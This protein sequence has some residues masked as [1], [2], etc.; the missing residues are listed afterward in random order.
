MFWVLHFVQFIQGFGQFHD[1]EAAEVSGDVGAVRAGSFFIECAALLDE[2]LPLGAAR[3]GGGPFG[4]T[5]A[6]PVGEVVLGEGASAEFFGEDALDFGQGIEPGEEFGA[7]GAVVEAMVEFIADEF[8]EAGDFSGAGFH[9]NLL[10]TETQRA[11]R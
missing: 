9:T 2:F 6:P 8:G 4:I 1:Q 11:Q 3:E 5:A 10:A 7:V